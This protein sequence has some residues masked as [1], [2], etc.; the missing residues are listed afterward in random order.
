MNHW[1]QKHYGDNLSSYNELREAK[2]A[3]WNAVSMTYLNELLVEMSTKIKEVVDAHGMHDRYQV[4]R[5]VLTEQSLSTLFSL[6]Q[7]LVIQRYLFP[8]RY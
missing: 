8:Y 4:S 3:T 5:L 2:T 6:R 1:K 7:A